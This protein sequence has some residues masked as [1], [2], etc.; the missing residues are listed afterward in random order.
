MAIYLP[1]S[2][3]T[4]SQEMRQQAAASITQEGLC[5]VTALVNGVQGVNVS[6]GS[7]DIFVGFSFTRTSAANF[8]PTTEVKVEQ[9]VIPA[10]GVVTLSRTPASSTTSVYDITDGGA[11]SGGNVSVSGAAVTITAS[12][13]RGAV[14][15]TVKVTYRYALTVAEAKLKYGDVTPGG[16][17]GNVTGTIGVAQQGKIFT[18][19]FDTTIDWTAAT[20]LKTGANGLVVTSGSGATINGFVTDVPTVDYPFLG[21]Q[22]AATGV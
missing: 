21:I 22:F 2:A 8:L 18:N 9:L 3:I 17:A 16:Y 11:V 19:A 5:L 13:T 14:G 12:S 6:A 10:G 1:L 15:N 7:S 20:T 4:R